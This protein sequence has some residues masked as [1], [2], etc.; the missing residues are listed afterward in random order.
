M[1]KSIIIGLAVALLVGTTNKNVFS[2]KRQNFKV[3]DKSDISVISSNPIKEMGLTN[4][5]KELMESFKKIR[6]PSN[7]KTSDFYQDSDEIL[8]AR[9]LLGECEGCSKIEKIAIAYTAINRMNNLK[10]WKNKTLKEV[11]LAPYQYSAFN[12]DK[13]AKLKDPLKY[14]PVEFMESLGLAG[15]IL[16]GKY[17]DPVTATHYLNPNH[18]DLKGRPLPKWTKKLEKLGRINNGFHVFYR[19]N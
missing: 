19:E 8:L 5:S 1:K 12:E 15:K 17:K 7:Y 11:I 14:N 2:N 3:F 6:N 18:P 13:N 10:E 4:I 9:M 16:A